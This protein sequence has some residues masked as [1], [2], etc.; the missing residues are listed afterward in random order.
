MSQVQNGKKSEKAEDK[1]Q[2][3]IL[4]QNK[5]KSMATYIALNENVINEQLSLLSNCMKQ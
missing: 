4:S 2:E 1:K 3:K 5:K